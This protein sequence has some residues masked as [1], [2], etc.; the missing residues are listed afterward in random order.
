M[1]KANR[2]LDQVLVGE[3]ERAS[4]EHVANRNSPRRMQPMIPPSRY[5]SK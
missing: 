4:R 2:A 3:N 5:V 1:A